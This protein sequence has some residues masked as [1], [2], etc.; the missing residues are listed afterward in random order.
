MYFHTAEPSVSINHI[1]G[2]KSV[3]R[4]ASFQSRIN[5]NGP[6]DKFVKRESNLGGECALGV[7]GISQSIDGTTDKEDNY[8]NSSRNLFD[9][10]TAGIV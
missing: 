4:R 3:D 1:G 10:T 7:I 5:F 6:F 8:M 2:K 9:P